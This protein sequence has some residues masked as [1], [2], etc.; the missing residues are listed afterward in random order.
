[1]NATSA[2]RRASSESLNFSRASAAF[3]FSSRTSCSKSSRTRSSSFFKS[4]KR[5][6]FGLSV[7]AQSSW[8]MCDAWICLSTSSIFFSC[9]L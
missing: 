4:L 3:S 9:V 7:S 5:F 6:A 2:S 8:L 1:M